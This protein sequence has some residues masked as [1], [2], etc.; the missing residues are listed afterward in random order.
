MK[1]TYVQAR[2][3]AH[4]F[5]H[6]TPKTG[7]PS[8]LS[9]KQIIPALLPDVRCPKPFRKKQITQIKKIFYTKYANIA[10]NS[11]FG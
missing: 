9:N 11:Y 5:M 2:A 8:S 1:M 3:S 6:L 7:A 10:I 4:K